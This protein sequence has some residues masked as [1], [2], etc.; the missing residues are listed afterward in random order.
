MP[1]PPSTHPLP[2]AAARRCSQV[3][4]PLASLDDEDALAAAVN[5]PEL[6]VE[7]CGSF[8]RTGYAT[9]ILRCTIDR[10]SGAPVLCASFAA[11]VQ[12]AMSDL[13]Q[14]F[15]PQR[16]VLSHLVMQVRHHP[17]RHLAS[18]PVFPRPPAPSRALP[19]S[20]RLPFS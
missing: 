1:T 9:P 19:H 15:G 8:I 6:L 7:F 20:S 14:R 4:L 17:R 16:I 3:K 10:S 2:F 11:S 13:S 5:V 12:I 18:P